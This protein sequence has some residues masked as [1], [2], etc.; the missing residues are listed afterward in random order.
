MHSWADSLPDP[1]WGRRPRLQEL[2]P[3][4]PLKR[5]DANLA[6]GLMLNHIYL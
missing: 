6:N 1:L 5:L 3:A 2:K 4:A